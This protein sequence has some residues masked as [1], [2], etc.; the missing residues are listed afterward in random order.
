MVS[1]LVS[2]DVETRLLVSR[3]FAF[4]NKSEKS[5]LNFK[6]YHPLVDHNLREPRSLNLFFFAVKWLRPR[7]KTTDQNRNGFV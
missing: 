7:F 3:S 2:R 5:C 6:G 4:W 1:V